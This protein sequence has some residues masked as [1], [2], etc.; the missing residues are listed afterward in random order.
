[1]A[2]LLTNTS[3]LTSIANAIR[4]KTGK[5]S[6]INFPNGFVSEIGSI[7]S[8]GS[9]GIWR[10]GSSRFSS[11]DTDWNVT[12]YDDGHILFVTGEVELG[13]EGL[14]TANI[15]VTGV[16]S[17]NS[18]IVGSGFFITDPAAGRICVYAEASNGFAIITA[19][20]ADPEMYDAENNSRAI[21]TIQI[22][23]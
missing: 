23:Y 19:S 16:S 3:E 10:D 18:H 12:I 11:A 5:T 14:T 15:S 7:S 17:N 22:P 9:G 2:N 4:S 20:V 13:L 6:S 21:I 1:M 8:S